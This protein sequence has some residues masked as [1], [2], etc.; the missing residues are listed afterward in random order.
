MSAQR[1]AYPSTLY[2]IA[3]FKLF[4]GLF[5]L[6]VAIT[7]LKLGP[8]GV[9][10]EVYRWADS[11]RVD[12]NSR[13]LRRLLVW[14]SLFDEKKLREL[15]VGTFFYSALFLTEGMGLA[16]RQ[17]WAE[18]FTII[19]TGS[20][21]PLEIYELARRPTFARGT[22]LLLNLAAVIYLVFDLR[23]RR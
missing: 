5:L 3:A 1:T 19:V 22:V 16:L 21:I 20:F 9:A 8:T 17:R 2:L 4:K 7:V 10:V 11:F 6:A 15:S 18:Y 14:L 23:R 12:P 13:L